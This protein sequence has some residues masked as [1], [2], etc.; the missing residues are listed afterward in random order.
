MAQRAVLVLELDARRLG[1]VLAEEVRRAGLQRLAVLHHRLDAV[2]ADRAGEP[3]AL[4]LLALDHRDGEPALG[5]V[6]VD[7]EHLHGLDEGFLLGRVRGVA[8]LPQELGGAQEEARPQL[9]ADNVVPEV[10]Q[11]RQ[12]TV[13]FHPF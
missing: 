4:G 1:E 6:G 10:E 12:V 8:L 11:D 13:G 2:G 9:P 3:L 5:E 7:A